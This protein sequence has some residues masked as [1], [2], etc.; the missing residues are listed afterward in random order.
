MAE[1]KSNQ[2]TEP[3][4][5]FGNTLEWFRQ[6]RYFKR[7]NQGNQQRKEPA[8]DLVSWLL[9]K[10][11]KVSLVVFGHGDLDEVKTLV[12]DDSTWDEIIDK[13]ISRNA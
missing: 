5:L 12:L 7:G 11:E 9:E 4:T 13:P 6:R 1:D 10:M 3:S 8:K 2:R